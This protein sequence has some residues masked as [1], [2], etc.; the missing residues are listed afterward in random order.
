MRRPART[1]GKRLRVRHGGNVIGF[2]LWNLDAMEEVG[3]VLEKVVGELLKEGFDLATKK[4]ACQAWFAI[5]HNDLP[6]VEEGDGDDILGKRPKDPS[7][8]FV[9]LPIGPEEDLAPTWSFSL[10]KMLDE[11]IDNNSS[12]DGLVHGED[13]QQLLDIRAV[14]S[15][16]ID[17]IDKAL[18]DGDL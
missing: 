15:G 7:T 14:Y 3:T 5:E 17:K 13:R 16:L 2:H 4:Y 6:G 18:E 9:R 1:K 8:I 12:G 11:V 10:S